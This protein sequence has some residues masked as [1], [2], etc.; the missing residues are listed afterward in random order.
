MRFLLSAL[1]LLI[2]PQAAA[3]TFHLGLEPAPAARYGAIPN[4]YAPL[5][6]NALPASHDLSA[7]MPPPGRQTNQSCVGWA[8]AYALKT[9]HER[10]ERRW[11]ITG[12]DGQPNP[13]HVFSP[14]FIYN[15]INGGEDRGSN[16]GDAFHVLATQGAAPWRAMPYRGQY[17]EPVSAAARAAA[18][19]YKIDT[20]R[21]ID[22]RNIA[23]MKAQIVAGF[24]IV[25]GA[26]V[27]R[28]LVQL[29]AGAVWSSV[30]GPAPNNHAMVVVG[31]DDN[32]QAFKIINSWG[33]EWS[34]GGYG[35][36]SYNLFP[37]VVNEAYIVVDLK[38]VDA[39]TRPS[40]DV[41]TP[42]TIAPEASSLSIFHVDPNYFE[43]SLGGA[44]GLRIQ[45][46]IT[47]PAGVRGVAQ[48]VIPLRLQG[49]GS[50]GSLSPA[51]MLP[52]G[53]AAFGTPPL[54]L[55]GAGVTNLPW[56][57]FI[58]YCALNLPKTAV[59]VP[60]PSPVYRPP[61]QSDLTAT[62]VLFIDNFGV[63]KGADVNFFVRL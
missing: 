39:Q 23:E 41:W 1:L 17:R 15:Q 21:K 32:R 28:E 25:I 13:D 40:D 51:Y 48:I 20:F 49:G 46:R 63:A 57:A 18:A 24:P 26:K 11:A 50:V 47:V 16:F 55:D 52:S 6:G 54:E 7:D 61:A 43:P 14:S 37:R 35:W 44:V 19:P 22:Q 59:C 36:I 33:P 34:S 5:I 31:Y 30:S 4:A 60:Y 58:P 3:Q 42:P 62:P 45:G 10:T 27:Y 12:P 38:G 2:A 53:Q 56:Y 8:V 9:Y 29:P